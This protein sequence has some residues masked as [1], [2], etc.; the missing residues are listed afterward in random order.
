[1]QLLSLP[2][3]HEVALPQIDIDIENGRLHQLQIVIYHGMIV[4]EKGIE[5]K[6]EQRRTKVS[7]GRTRMQALELQQLAKRH[8]SRRSDVKQ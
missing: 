3:S 7:F 4:A 1:M 8:I 5:N 2:C 6:G